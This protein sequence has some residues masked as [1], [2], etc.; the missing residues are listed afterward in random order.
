MMSDAGLEVLSDAVR[1][2]DD[3]CGVIGG[4]GFVGGFFE[5]GEPALKV[6]GIEGELKVFHHGVA[7]VST[8]GEKDG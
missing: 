6:V 5:E 7:F 8:R 3:R 1:F 4:E 2:F